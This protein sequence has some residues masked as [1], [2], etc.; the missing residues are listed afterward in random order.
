MKF[1]VAVHEG[2]LYRETRL[3]LTAWFLR[4]SPNRSANFDSQTAPLR[5]GFSVSGRA[6]E[7]SLLPLRLVWFLVCAAV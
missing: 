4:E 7:L 6:I 5:R 2:V 1:G 3:S